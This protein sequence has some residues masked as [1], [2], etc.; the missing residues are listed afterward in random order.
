M[1]LSKLSLRNAKRQAGD[2][3]VYF[4]TIIMAAALLYAFN[5]LIFSQEIK[6]L[7]RRMS[8]LSAV[9][10]LASIVVVCIFGWLVSY[11]SNFMLTRRSREMGL[12]ILIGLENKQ[13]ARLFFLENLAVGGAALV[14]GLLLGN[15]LFQILRAI[16]LTLFGQLYHFAFEFSLKAVGLTVVYFVLL[17][18][19]ALRKSQKRIRR[20]KIYDLI[21]FDRQNEG[22]VIQTS[23][24]RRWIFSG[25]IVLGVMGTFLLMAR[26][27]L[28][29][30]IGAGCVILFLYGFF[31]S[32]A[33]GVP[34]FFDKRPARK[35]RE[36]NL[37]VFRTLTAKLGTMGVT[38][39]T[40]S[41][42]FAATLMAEGTGLV[43]R[44]ILE[45]RAAECECCDLY[46]GTEGDYP[47]NE[48]YLDYIENNIPVEASVMY[49]VYLG[50]T[51]QIMDD[52]DANI[53][54]YH[55]GY[56]RDPL[57]RYSDYA[58]LRA[59]AGY[60][61]A[62]LVQGQYII[63]CMIYLAEALENNLQPVTVGDVVLAPGDIYTEHLLQNSWSG[64]GPGYI[65]VVPDEV[66]EHCRVHH[67]AYA[68]KTVL[69]VSEEQ[70]EM[71]DNIQYQLEEDGGT[72]ERIVA[73]SMEEAEAASMVAIT[74]FP[75]YFLSLALVMTTATILTIQQLSESQRYRK[76]FGLLHKL[77]MD[78]QEMRKALRMQFTFYYAMP[79]IPAL[80]I[81]VPFILNLAK[82]PEPGV[83]V[84]A[85]SPE[86]IVIIALTVF[87]LIYA[88]YILM[89]YT[90]LK[91]NVLPEA[92]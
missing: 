28:I 46:I 13:V 34:A 85:S 64:N 77:G 92:L 74:V 86:A 24:K 90:S 39:A 78:R 55:Y 4:A 87:F 48:E 73:K 2:Y 61:T 69:P 11:A 53:V 12:Y 25:S 30:I 51:S 41:L 22:E 35:Y 29:G 36:Q 66:T 7:S 43:F 5:G 91:R 54:Y 32:F 1:T 52:I 60:R 81:S 21:Y 63:H 75:L 71:L 18:L 62:E 49:H 42:L 10:V 40:I 58:A 83:M 82:A 88:V 76:Q 44:G 56:D 70:F 19:Y 68:A 65:L 16:V 27:L 8:M 45:G 50:E 20:M 26:D 17:Y 33:S 9:I 3:L 23:R 57:M 80:L 38:M 89:A 6:E 47:I 37:L 79:A 84:G 31:L 14:L 59:A 15:L 72:Y 67:R